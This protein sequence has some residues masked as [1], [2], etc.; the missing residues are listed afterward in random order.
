MSSWCC[1]CLKKITVWI[2][3]AS[4]LLLRLGIEPLYLKTCLSIL[5]NC[6][7][8]LVLT[9]IDIEEIAQVIVKL[10]L[11]FTEADICSVDMTGPGCRGVAESTGLSACATAYRYLCRLT[12]HLLCLFMFK[13]LRQDSFA[14]TFGYYLIEAPRAQLIHCLL[15]AGPHLFQD[16]LSTHPCTHTCTYVGK[17][18]VS[19]SI[20]LTSLCVSFSSV[21]L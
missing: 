17:S 9:I 13:A 1:V 21:L 11:G 10:L 3:W 5:R 14:S 6:C 18:L 20:D 15:W 12:D 2:T 19:T 7:D 8:S 16:C 4:I